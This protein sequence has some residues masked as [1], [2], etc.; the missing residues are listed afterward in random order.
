[1][2]LFDN[3]KPFRERNHTIIGFVGIAVLLA[4][5]VAAFRADRLPIIGAGDTYKANF[6]DVGGLNVGDEVRVA[7]VTVGKVKNIELEGANAVVS[8]KL[9]KGTELGSQTAA[10]VKV[11][12]MLGA[13]YL[14]LVPAGSGELAKGSTIPASRTKAPYNIVEAFQELSTTTDEIDLDQVASALNALADIAEETPEEFRGAIKGVSDLSVN[15]A[16]R[17]EQINTLLVNLRRVSEVLNDQGPNLV[18]FFEDSSE[19]FDALADRRKTIHQLLKGTQKIS[20]ELIKLVDATKADL[21]PVLTKLEIVTDMLRRNEAS[22]D[23][24]LRAYPPLIHGF[25]NALAAGPWWDTF[26]KAGG[27]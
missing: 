14:G 25:S 20:S 7:G 2:A 24:A 22:I 8:F 15:L 6:A 19:L 5:M 10:E 27:A 13:E 11:R 26:I 18:A 1:M 17:D 3:M 23:E 16:A 12:T 9:D 21:N 4:V